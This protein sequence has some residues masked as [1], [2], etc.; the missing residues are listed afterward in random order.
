[1]LNSN[2]AWQLSDD[3][4]ESLNSGRSQDP[5]RILG[6]HF[7]S[8]LCIAR[9]YVPGAKALLVETL[10]GEKLGNLSLRHEAGFFEGPINLKTR[11]PILYQASNEHSVWT[12]VDPYTFGPV[13][14][15]LDDYFLSEGTHQNLYDRLGAH[16]IQH[17]GVEGVHF[18]LW[19]PNAQRV[20]VVGDFNHWDGRIHSMRKRRDVGIWEIF[21]PAAQR[22]QSY[23]YELIDSHGQILPLKSDPFGFLFE[24]R[25]QTASRIVD[26]SHFNWTDQT[27]LD[28][29]LNLDLRSSPVLIYEVHLGSWKRKENNAYLT[30]DELADDLLNYVRNM[31]FT[32]IELMPIAEH[33]YDPSWGYQPI[34]LFAPTSRFGD[35]SGFARFINRAHEFDIGVILDWVPGHFPKDIHGLANFDGTA[36]YEHSDPRQG[37][38]PDWDTA[39]YNFGRREVQN[40]LVNNSLFWLSKYHLDGLRV[41]AVASMLYLD[42]SRKEGEWVPNHKGGREN[43]EAIKF[44]QQ[45]NHECYSQNPGIV[46][47]AEESTSFPGVTQPPYSG[48]LGF[49]FKWNMGFMNDSLRYLRRHPSQ[50]HDYHRELTFSSMYSFS[51]NF[52]LPLSHDE[53]VH[54]KGSLLNKMAGDD[55]QK[56]ATLRAFYAYMWGHPGKKLLFMGQELAPWAEWSESRSLDWGLTSYGPHHGMQNLIRDLNFTYRNNPA[57]YARDCDRDGLEWLLADDS[58]NS[59]YAWARHSGTGSNPVVIVTNFHHTTKNNYL[60]PLPQSGFWRE[61]INT[62]AIIYGGDGVGNMGGVRAEPKSA[63]YKPASAYIVIPPL[64]TMYFVLGETR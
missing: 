62:N 10:N 12:F 54:G 61:I 43:L 17:E 39:I 58:E 7:F 29:R 3:E 40:F 4:I 32:H 55:L 21:I 38:H 27:F 36:L 53:V 15:P 50:R 49:G 47:I 20:S 13:L 19:A 25:P 34:G 5:L 8:D 23:K 64:T 37:L 6:I 22:G 46:T 52:I 44:L 41:D 51:E 18:A 57:L 63:Y 42:Y 11:Q 9:A 45:M 16:L 48:G 60:L 56:F 35:P 26:T 1:M 2:L 14:G 24:Y 30:Y 28:R 33:P 59:V 31:G